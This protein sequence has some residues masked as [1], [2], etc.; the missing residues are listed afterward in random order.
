[1]TFERRLPWFCAS[2]LIAATALG[3][4]TMVPLPEEAQMSVYNNTT[5]AITIK[6]KTC[7]DETNLF[8]DAAKLN[9][10]SAR[11]IPI[12]EACVDAQAVDSR[13]RIVGTQQRLRAPP[14]IV[15]NIY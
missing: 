11:V 10:K 13:G 8:W 9:P 3:C 15:W 7:D 5:R 12:E 2:T 4:V 1:M 6:F 14:E